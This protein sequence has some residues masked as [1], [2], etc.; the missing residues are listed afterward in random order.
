M[1]QKFDRI[2]QKRNPDRNY[3]IEPL[4]NGDMLLQVSGDVV[5]LLEQL[6][7]TEAAGEQLRLQPTKITK[8]LGIIIIIR[9]NLY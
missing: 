5:P 9:D 3:N 2:L 1:W 8:L 4:T 6:T 7:R